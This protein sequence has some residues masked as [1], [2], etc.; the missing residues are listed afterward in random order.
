MII[1]IERKLK[2]IHLTPYR[3]ITDIV[4]PEWED[5]KFPIKFRE[6]HQNQQRY[7]DKR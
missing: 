5:I 6:K 2:P 7:F 3:T 1:H 4:N